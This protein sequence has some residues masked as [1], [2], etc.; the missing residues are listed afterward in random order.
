[1]IKLTKKIAGK[2][3]ELDVIFLDGKTVCRNTTYTDLK[4]KGITRKNLL[5]AGFEIEEAEKKPK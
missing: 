1:M 5:D 2:E 4:K 3:V